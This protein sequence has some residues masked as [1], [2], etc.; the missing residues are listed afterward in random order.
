MT[1]SLQDAKRKV[2]ARYLG[3]HGIHGVGVR[4]TE[5]AICVYLHHP[6]GPEQVETLKAIELEL[7]PIKVIKV[8]EPA[9]S[10]GTATG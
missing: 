10:A 4:E 9:P 5:G 6:E 7:A 3:K 8:I 2:R 1:D